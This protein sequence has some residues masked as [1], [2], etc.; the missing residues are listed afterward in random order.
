MIDEGV[1]CY[2]MFTTGRHGRPPSW[3][4]NLQLGASCFS[5][6]LARICI[7]EEEMFSADEQSDVEEAK[8]EAPDEEVPDVDLT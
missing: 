6:T 2:T 3:G 8:Q 7:A 5:E 4:S 1:N